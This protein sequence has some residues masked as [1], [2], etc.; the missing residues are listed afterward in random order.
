MSKDILQPE[1]INILPAAMKFLTFAKPKIQAF[2]LAAS[3]AWI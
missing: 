2:C 3:T 1:K